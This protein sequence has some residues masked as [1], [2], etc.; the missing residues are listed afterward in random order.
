MVEWW[1]GM[2]LVQQIFACMAVPASVILVIQSI[3]LLFGFGDHGDMDVPDMD[4]GGDMDFGDHGADGLPDGDGGLALFSIRGIMAFFAVGGWVG[5]LLA[6]SGVNTALTAIIAFVAGA[7]ALV[8]LA[9]IMKASL[10]LQD[11]GTM[12]IHNAIGKTAQVYLPIPASGAGS[13][14]VH[15]TFQDR[16]TELS[17]ITNDAQPIPTGAF[18]QVTGVIGADSVQVTQQK[19]EQQ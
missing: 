12:D 10:K 15:V 17:A 4:T 19:E 9:F 7:A 2:N 6:G 13:G 16:Y 8:G 1:N 14:K 5:V 18:V 3:L 11:N